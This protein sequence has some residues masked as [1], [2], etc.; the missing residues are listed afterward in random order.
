MS[1][2]KL[3]GRVEVISNRHTVLILSA[4]WNGVEDSFKDFS[5]ASEVTFGIDH[6]HTDPMSICL[7]L[8]SAFQCLLLYPVIDRFLVKTVELPR[9]KCWL[10]AEHCSGG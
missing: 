7:E 2:A 1:T 9:S 8:Q 5:V 3:G 10:N 4:Q 6:R